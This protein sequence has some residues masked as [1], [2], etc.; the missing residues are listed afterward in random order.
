MIKRNRVSRPLLLFVLVVGHKPADTD[1]RPTSG[2]KQKT[3][4]EVAESMKKRK[5]SEHSPFT[6]TAKLSPLGERSLFLRR[7]FPSANVQTGYWA[8]C[9]LGSSQIQTNV[10]ETELGAD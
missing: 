10:Q 3:A 9:W 2:K 6:G 7:F 8:K 4:L 1:R 5:K